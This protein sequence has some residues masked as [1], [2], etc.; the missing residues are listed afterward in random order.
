MYNQTP[1]F[2]GYY[3]NGATTAQW[4]LYKWAKPERGL[5]PSANIE[6]LQT[7]LHVSS[8]RYVLV[9]KRIATY[10]LAL[11]QMR[12]A[13]FTSVAWQTPNL[14]ILE[15]SGWQSLAR[16][17]TQSA[18]LNAPSLAAE[19][20]LLPAADRAGRAIYA[21]TGS[22]QRLAGPPQSTTLTRQGPY[23]IGVMV[24][25]D[26]EGVLVV[27]E[28]WHPNW[29]VTV[30]GKPAE[31]LRANVAFMGVRLDAGKHDVLYSYRLPATLVAG[32]A[33]SLLTVLGLLVRK[34]R[35]GA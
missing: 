3:D 19:L 23:Q 1:R 14:T 6:A 9:H 24:D 2:G 29:R 27:A 17:Y 20:A 5:T 25:A 15:D 34:V 4:R 26:S 33:I 7:A 30:D 32:W 31:L 16:F 12:E 18:A 13:G 21:G 35:A 11:A 10:D 22:E 28:S 8:V